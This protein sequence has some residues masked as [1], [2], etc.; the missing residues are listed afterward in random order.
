M[1]V[2]PTDLS[3]DGVRVLIDWSKFIVGTS[4]FV[5]CI[6]TK[7]A[8][9]HIVEASQIEKTDLVKR[10]CI[11]KGKYGLRVWRMR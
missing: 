8:F 10:V 9:K 2:K 11:E 6:N 5:P 3:P 1:R 4:I 7:T